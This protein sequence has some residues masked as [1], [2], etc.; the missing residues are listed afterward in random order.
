MR[1]A[2][3]EGLVDVAPLDRGRAAR[4]AVRRPRTG[5]GCATELGLEYL[6]TEDV[7]ELGAGGGRGAD[8]RAGR[9]P[10]GVHQL[11][12]RRR[13]PGA[14]RRAPGRPRP[15]GRRRATMLA[16]LRGLTGI[17]FVG[18]DVVEVIPA[19]DPAGQ[20][21]TL[22]ANLAYEMLSLVALRR[23]AAGDRATEA[24]RVADAARLPLAGRRAGG[25]LLHVRPRR[26]EPD[27]VRPSRGR[28]LARRDEP[29]G[30]RAADRRAAA[31][32]A[33]RPAGRS[34][35][36]SSSRATPPS[37]GPTRCARSATP[38]TRSPTTATSTRARTAP[39]PTTE[40]R[41]LLRGLEALDAVARRPPDRLSRPE[42]GAHLRHAGAPRPA[43]LP[44]TTA[45]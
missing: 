40:E 42:L 28:R 35:R 4:V 19:Y 5:P 16:I 15:A 14:T 25:G 7:F 36:R 13:R 39:T 26:R 38:A 10:A 30:V 21:A 22:A 29:P 41:R 27:P 24:W 23:R 9:R 18:F 11:R 12:H 3:E 1:R 37:A 6:T 20:T 43:R 8:P 34:G 17:D 44:R 32:A 45:G 31:A 2:I 33:A